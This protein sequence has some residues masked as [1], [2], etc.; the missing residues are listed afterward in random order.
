METVQQICYQPGYKV[1]LSI[2][3]KI[4]NGMQ[5]STV[6][7]YVSAIK[8]SLVNDGY[9]WDDQKVLLGLLTKACKVIND[10]VHTRLPI[11][12]GLLEMLL[13]KVQ[14]MF[15]ENNQFYLKTM[16]KALFAVSYCGMMKV[17]EVTQVLLIIHVVKAPHVHSATNIR[18]CL[19]C[20]PPNAY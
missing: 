6:K 4:D 3:Y 10:K 15:N 11:Q 8:K 7:S 13:F 16:Y 14:R 5:S 20:T 1:T 9:P 12:Y 19:C 2:G 17:C 18:Y